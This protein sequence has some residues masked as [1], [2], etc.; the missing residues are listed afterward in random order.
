[1]THDIPVTGTLRGRPFEEVFGGCC[2][3]R[4]CGGVLS[5]SGFVV[6]SGSL[7]D[8]EKSCYMS[9]C[10]ARSRQCLDG[11]S[12]ALGSVVQQRGRPVAFSSEKQKGFKK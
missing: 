4:R 10:E 2:G 6:V 5:P 8:G 1:M 9:E 12:S 11:G 3:T 7:R